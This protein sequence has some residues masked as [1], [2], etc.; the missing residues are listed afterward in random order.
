MYFARVLAG[1]YH[2]LLPGSL[3]AC[4]LHKWCFHPD[5]WELSKWCVYLHTCLLSKQRGEHWCGLPYMPCQVGEVPLAPEA[6][7]V[8]LDIRVVG[9]DSGEKV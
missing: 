1:G 9:N 8:G 6:A 5:A 3:D 4:M 7:S 2:Q